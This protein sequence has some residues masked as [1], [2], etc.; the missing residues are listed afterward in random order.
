MN[1]KYIY[2]LI[3]G[4][5][6]YSAVSG[7]S[8]AVFLQADNSHQA[9]IVVPGIPKPGTTSS[10]LVNDNQ[11]KTESCPLNG[12]LYSKNQRALWVSRRPMGVMIENHVDARPQ[13]GLS[14]ADVVYE[15]VAEGG[16]T[17]FLAMFYCQDAS[18]IGPIRSARKYFIDFLSEY[19]RYPIYSHVGGA[20]AAGDADALSLIDSY[21]WTGY[22]DL[23]QFSI[24]YPYYYRDYTRLGS[25]VATEHTMYAST[26]KLWELAKSRGITNV[27]KKTGQSWDAEFKP[28]SFVDDID[29]SQRGLAQTVHLEFWNGDPSYYV[30]WK[31]DRDTDLY[32]RNNGG[33]VHLDKDTDKPLTSRSLVVLYMKETHAD[34]GYENNIH[35]LYQDI[36][37]GK[38]VVMFDGKKTNIV[39]SKATRTERTVL[40]TPGGKEVQF[41][42]GTIW[43]S[44]LPLDA[45]LNV[46]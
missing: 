27:D 8:Y 15:A 30:D 16:I 39:W 23:N 9:N 28:Y 38:G 41:P 12:V 46:Q 14:S 21:G 44:I 45:V 18:V 2:L 13:S 31:Y 10:T 3:L 35:L 42:R 37:S 33:K 19:G 25:D 4:V 11:P 32:T 7:I 36:G 34:D 24:G 6:V 22:N 26:Q 17:R 43:F 40:T 1:V 20:N 29:T 5:V